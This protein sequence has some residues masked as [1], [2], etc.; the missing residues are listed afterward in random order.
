MV[1]TSGPCY[2]D[3]QEVQFE[4]LG[5]EPEVTT[6]TKLRRR[7]FTFSAMQAAEAIRACRPSEIFLNFANYC[8]DQVPRIINI[9]EG[10]INDNHAPHEQNGG[11]RYVG[12][13]PK[14]SDVR[15]MNN[16]YTMDMGPDGKRIK[17]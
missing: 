4:D 9:L 7:V 14:E 8:P 17:L 1:G 10:L 2:P 6:V 13:G 5:V 12:W 16:Q 15:E 11:V 3:Q